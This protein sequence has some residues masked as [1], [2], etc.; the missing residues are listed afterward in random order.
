MP[1]V[2]RLQSRETERVAAKT[3]AICDLS[4]L[5]KLGV[6]GLEAEDWLSDREVDV[7]DAVYGSCRLVGDGN[8]VRVA[9]DEFLLESGVNNDTVQTL[10]GQLNSASGNVYSVP[11]QEATFLLIGSRSVD[12]LAQMCGINFHESPLRKLILTRVAGVN[13]GIFPDLVQ[14]AR[15]FRLWVDY[16][17]AVYLWESLVRICEDLDGIVAGASCIFPELL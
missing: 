2:V 13:C 16:T 9:C 7:P 8:I 15:A 1:I 14:D 4:S 6:K 5:A 3:L 11:R 12:V 10:A 17:Y